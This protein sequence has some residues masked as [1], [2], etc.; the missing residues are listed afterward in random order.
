MI[1]IRDLHHDSVSC[2]SSWD[3]GIA[4]DVGLNTLAKVPVLRAGLLNTLY[5][6]N[7]IAYLLH[8]GSYKIF[9]P[10]RFPLVLRL[11]P[12]CYATMRLAEF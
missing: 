5:G 1:T 2:G 6:H 8:H 11:W 7:G 3:I 12:Y 9:S 10:L 4:H